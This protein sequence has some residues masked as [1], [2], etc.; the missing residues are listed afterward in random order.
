MK[1]KI[2]CPHCGKEIEIEKEVVEIGFDAEDL[3]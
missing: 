2:V 1:R 3:R